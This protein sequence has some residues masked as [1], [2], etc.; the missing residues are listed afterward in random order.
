MKISLDM[1]ILLKSDSNHMILENF[2]GNSI[3]K[4]ISKK[5]GKY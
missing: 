3:F 2:T 4:S 1:L 5:T